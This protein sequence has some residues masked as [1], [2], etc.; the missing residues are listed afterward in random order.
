MGFDTMKCY[1]CKKLFDGNEF[2]YWLKIRILIKNVALDVYPM[3]D[4]PFCK[5][6]VCQKIGGIK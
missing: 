3:E 2:I 1:K 5:L 4:G 6:C